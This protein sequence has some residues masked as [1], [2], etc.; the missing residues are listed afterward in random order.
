MELVFLFI[1]GAIVGSFL[2]VVIYRY[3]IMLEREWR[4]DCLH[5]LK[6]PTV[7]ETEKFNLCVPRSHCIHCKKPVPYR[8]NIPILS[9]IMLRGKCHFCHARFSSQHLCV[10]IISALLPIFIFLQFG[11]TLPAFALMIFS[12][13]L[14]TLSFIDIQHQFLPDVITYCLLWIGLLL[15]L[16]HYFVSPVDAILGAIAGYL[17]LW[18]IAK[19]Y[20]LLRKKEGMG[21]GDCKMLA[22]IGA[23]VGLNGLVSVLLIASFIGLIIN[24]VLVLFKKSQYENPIS[25][26]PYLAIGGW[27]T[28]VYGQFILHWIIQWIQ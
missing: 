27:C 24:L 12:W 1:L 17:F 21:L 15:S 14:I 6:Q 5:F 9:F 16:N 25:F 10:E 18:C 11:V 22:M 13:G 8:F 2:N 23:W 28:A 19:I 4:R 20:L 26:G 3:P 7:D